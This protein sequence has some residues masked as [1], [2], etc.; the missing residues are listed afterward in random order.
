MTT[1]LLLYHNVCKLSWE[2]VLFGIF[3]NATVDSE[4]W[5][6]GAMPKQPPFS[7]KLNWWYNGRCLIEGHCITVVF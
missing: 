4:L 6:F 1:I 2:S 5:Q 7:S 3:R